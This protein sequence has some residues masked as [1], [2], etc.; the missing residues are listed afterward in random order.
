MHVLNVVLGGGVSSRLFQK[1]REQHGVAY[2]IYSWL[3]SFSD[4]GLLTIYAATR[5]KEV[6]RVLRYIARETGALRSRGMTRQE[7]ET[8]KSHLQGSLMLSVESTHSRMNKLAK[9]EL[10]GR[11]SL[12]LKDMLEEIDRVTMDHVQRLTRELVNVGEMEL[13]AIGPLFSRSV[14]AARM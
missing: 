9:D 1:V 10:Y 11:P 7:L 4:A 14:R 6:G 5:P 13:S 2:S 3:S 12:V 8:A